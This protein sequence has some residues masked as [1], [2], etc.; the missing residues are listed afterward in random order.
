MGRAVSALLSTCSRAGLASRRRIRVPRSQ[1]VAHPAGRR[2]P[3]RLA[4][5]GDISSR[6]AAI[7]AGPTLRCASQPS[8]MRVKSAYAAPPQMASSRAADDAVNHSSPRPARR[9]AAL[10]RRLRGRPNRATR[11]ARDRSG[12]ATNPVLCGRME[13]APLAVPRPS[14]IL[15]ACSPST[16][17][18]FGFNE[19]LQNR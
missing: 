15:A 17:N 12:P 13:T 6:R 11:H 2:Q 8:L 1:A 5:V 10:A 9:V 16:P 7:C 18:G 4:S 19:I 14:P 3:R